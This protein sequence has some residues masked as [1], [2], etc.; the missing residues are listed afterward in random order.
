MALRLGGHGGF[1]VA[2]QPDHTWGRGGL[3]AGRPGDTPSR[4][5]GAGGQ[6]QA[7]VDLAGEIDWDISVDSTIV[8]AHQ[9][10]AGCP[11]RPTAGLRLKGG[12][13]A[14]TS[15]RNRVAEPVRPP[16]GGGAGG[17]G[18]GRSRGE[19]TTK[20]HLSADGGCRPLPLVVTPGQ[21]AH[22]TQFKPVLE[23]IRVPKTGPGRP[24]EKP[25]SLAAD[26]AHGNEPYRE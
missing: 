9:H 23:K 1:G 24:R 17:E 2:T 25:D 3:S 19:F 15:G 11:H 18:L 12:R 13:R 7:T 21:R 22:C 16:G 4:S 20:L 26:K 10:A 8:R 6:V 5:A 14:R